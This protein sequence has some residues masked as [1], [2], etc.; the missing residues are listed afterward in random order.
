MASDDKKNASE[1]GRIVTAPLGQKHIPI[2]ERIPPKEI[3]RV[4]QRE[5]RNPR[6]LLRNMDDKFKF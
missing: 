3:I 5:Q 4:F 1:A 6:A 2:W